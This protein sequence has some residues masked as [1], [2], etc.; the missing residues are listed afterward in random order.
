[1][2]CSCDAIMPSFFTKTMR[3]AVRQH[4][5]SECR[6]LIQCGERY[7]FISGKWEGVIHTYKSCS[8]CLAVRDFLEC[9]AHCYCIEFTSVMS[10]AF[11]YMHHESPVGFAVGRL[12]VAVRQAGGKI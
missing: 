2:G 12:L 10:D 9:E 8:H 7:E 5:C 3:Q 6:R 11:E 4:K 1:M